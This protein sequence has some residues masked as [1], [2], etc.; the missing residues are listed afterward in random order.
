M[1]TMTQPRTRQQRKRDT[2]HR[3]EH[4]VDAWVA[5]TDGRAGGDAFAAKTGFDPRLLTSAE[6]QQRAADLPGEAVADLVGDR[7][8]EQLPP[9]GPGHIRPQQPLEQHGHDE[10]QC[11]QGHRERGKYPGPLGNPAS[12]ALT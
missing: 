11:V 6:H 2:L 3:L 9:L 12:G 7:L 5:T 8:G 4:D 10:R 1:P